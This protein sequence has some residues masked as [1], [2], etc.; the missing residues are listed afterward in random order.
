AEVL[1]ISEQGV[2]NRLLA[3]EARLGAEMYH[4]QRGVR[5][6]APL[7]AAGRRFL[8]HA[9]AFL[10]RARELGDLFH[11]ARAIHEVHVAAS[12]YLIMYG[13][14]AVIRGFRLEAPQ[15]RIRLS[16]RSEESIESEL[17]SNQ[18]VALGIAAPHE[19]S[20]ELDY[21]HLF[22]MNWSLIAPPKH[23]ILAKP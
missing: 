18:D 1:H 21:L 3:L 22:S 12:Q 13:L 7:T 17:L 23:P 6:A 10:E 4:K 19:P 2:R 9:H 16:T 15:V 20:H 11:P 5:R 8:P 14:I